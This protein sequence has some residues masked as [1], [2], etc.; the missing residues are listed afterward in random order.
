V[1]VAQAL[2]RTFC[3]FQNSGLRP[4]ST[5]GDLWRHRES[6]SPR[7]GGIGGA[8]KSQAQTMHHRP[9]NPRGALPLLRRPVVTAGVAAAAP[10]STPSNS[11]G[12]VR[13]GRWSVDSI[14]EPT[15]LIHFHC[16]GCFPCLITIKLHCFRFFQPL[17][18]TITMRLI[19]GLTAAALSGLAVGASQQSADV[20]IF[21]SSSSSSS[22]QQAST[23]NTPS[24]PK[25]VA[26]HIL[27]Q[28]ASHPPLSIDA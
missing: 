26:R 14:L 19:A 20:Y 16:L 4:L 12:P 2:P 24:I 18:S 3:H 9:R 7:P 6:L 25:E 28:R 8:K 1:V 11:Q 10:T 27:L 17:A 23:G 13:G 5:L 22:N 15:F 21:S